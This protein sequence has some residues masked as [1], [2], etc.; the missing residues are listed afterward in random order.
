MRLFPAPRRRLAPAIL[1]AAILLAMAPSRRAA[2]QDA[3]TPCERYSAHDVIFIG[4]AGAPVSRWI[5]SA[6]SEPPAPVTVTPVNVE[7]TFR[8]ALT[9]EVFLW[10]DRPPVPA[11]RRYVV[12]GAHHSAE[13]Q[14]LITPA[15]VI[16]VE[17]AAD[18]LE[19]LDTAVWSQSG[20]TIQGTLI[21][22]TA[23]DPDSRTPLADV[24]VRVSGRGTTAE[25]TTNEHGRFVVNGIP[26]GIARIEP[27][28]PDNQTG[29]V[30]ADVRAGGCTAVEIVARR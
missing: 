6:P 28:L 22:A 12:Y 20:G 8:G 3:T 26:P 15:L 11:G 24:P 19:L 13:N 14:N 16:P 5:A 7:R 21:A 17:E 2:A 29:E 1:A 9:S 27:L 4:T 10:L 23:G 18:D 25:A 30:T